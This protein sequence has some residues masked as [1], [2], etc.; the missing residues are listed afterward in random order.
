MSAFFVQLDA[1]PKFLPAQS[2]YVSVA[3]RR[4]TDPEVPEHA[5][6]IAEARLSS[7]IAVE[8]CLPS[9]T[10]LVQKRKVEPKVAVVAIDR[11]G[12]I[13]RRNRRFVLRWAAQ[14][15]RVR[16]ER[17]QPAARVL[18]GYR[19]GIELRQTTR[20]D[21]RRALRRSRLGQ[22]WFVRR[23]T[24]RERYKRPRGQTY[25]GRVTRKSIRKANRVV[26]TRHPVGCDV[27]QFEP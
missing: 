4:R 21:H 12:L 27:R 17:P 7:Q 25:D 10:P 5:S 26:L 11:E 14:T 6:R 13:E 2:G 8:A 20:G 3:D 22:F 16:A 23:A 1:E 19:G 15:Q 18:V 9:T 24:L